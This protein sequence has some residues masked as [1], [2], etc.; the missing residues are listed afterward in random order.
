MG[1]RLEALEEKFALELHAITPADDC[2]V[3]KHR[4]SKLDS[5]I[6]ELRDLTAHKHLQLQERIEAKLV[7]LEASC[8]T[9][10]LDAECALSNLQM[11]RVHKNDNATDAASTDLTDRKMENDLV[12]SGDLKELVLGTLHAALESM[13]TLVTMNLVEV[14]MKIDELCVG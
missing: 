12:R 3:L 1:A 14:E 11:E 2:S 6:M 4:M 5:D 9:A 8:K 7:D 13:A 10:S